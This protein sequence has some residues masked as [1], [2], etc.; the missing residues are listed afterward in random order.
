MKNIFIT[1]FAA[2]ALLSGCETQ[3]QQNA[4][5]KMSEPLQTTPA[6]KAWSDE[7]A[8][9]F[10]NLPLILKEIYLSTKPSGTAQYNDFK[11]LDRG[12]M[13]LRQGQNQKALEVFN[14][15]ASIRYPEETN[16]AP[17]GGQ[18]EAYCATGDKKAGLAVINNMQCEADLLTDKKTCV[19]M[20]KEFAQ[21]KPGFPV[22]CYQEICGSEFIRP[23]YEASGEA[24]TSAETKTAN[25]IET[26]NQNFINILKKQCTV[27]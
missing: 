14:R 3:G 7:V 25:R 16:F 5:S 1:A 27:R 13:L 22:E 10:S 24:F 17:W 26:D 8:Q 11:E 15:L 20:D 9:N 4:S 12:Y 18:A 21:K 6:S 19:Q 2:V 23:D